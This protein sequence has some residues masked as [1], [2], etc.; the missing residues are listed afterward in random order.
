MITKESNEQSLVYKA[1]E[2][3]LKVAQIHPSRSWVIR[4]PAA[5]PPA[6][7]PAPAPEKP[8]S[9]EPTEP[10]KQSNIG[11]ILAQRLTDALQG[12]DM[13]NYETR[14]KAIYGEL[15]AIAREMKQ[16]D[17]LS[18]PDGTTFELTFKPS[19]RQAETNTTVKASK[20]LTQKAQINPT[21]STTPAPVPQLDEFTKAYIEAALWSSTDESTPQGGEPLDKNYTIQ[22]IS[23][24]TL[25][26]MIS[27]CK[28]FQEAQLTDGTPVFDVI[29]SNLAR[30]GHDFWLTRNR[31]GAGFWDGDWKQFGDLLTEFSHPYGDFNLYV[32]DDHKI[33]GQ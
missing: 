25:Q 20:S 12:V 1:L 22:D 26:Q 33:H 16:G 8:A 19:A 29:S 4:T 3:L 23:P 10:A 32:G 24:E 21:P 15:S 2:P 27:D 18:F 28:D 7:A 30:A 5:Q 13:T 6:P 31:H 9:P 14:A 11:F 17:W